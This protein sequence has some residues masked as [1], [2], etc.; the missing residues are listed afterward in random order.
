LSKAEKKLYLPSQKFLGKQVIDVK[1]TLIGNVKDLAVSVGE[2]DLELVVVTKASGE[3][4]VPWSEIES[5]EDVVLLNKKL[6]L[7]RI[8]EAPLVTPIPTGPASNIQCPSCKATVPSHAKFCPK[9]GS[10]IR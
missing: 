1:G 3:I 5:I 9:C 4:Q 10:R 8:P 7:P 2:P 6:E